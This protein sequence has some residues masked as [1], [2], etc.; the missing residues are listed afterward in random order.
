LD[1]ALYLV[2]A[3]LYLMGAVLYLLDAVLSLFDTARR[4]QRSSCA[5]SSMAASIQPWTAPGNGH[6]QP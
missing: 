5:I 6:I 2:G 1:A 3:V 4:R